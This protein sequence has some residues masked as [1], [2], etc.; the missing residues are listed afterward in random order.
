MLLKRKQP[1]AG[2]NVCEL[3]GLSH[4][5]DLWRGSKPFQDRHLPRKVSKMNSEILFETQA[6]RLARRL[7]LTFD[8]ARLLAGLAFPPK[9]ARL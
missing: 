7:G 6:R 3:I 8:R 1:A 2:G 5:R 4:I 9:E